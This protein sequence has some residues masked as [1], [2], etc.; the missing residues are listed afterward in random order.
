LRG[1][2][3]TTSSANDG[4][5]GYVSVDGLDLYYKELDLRLEGWS[6]EEFRRS[7]R[8]RCS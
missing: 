8:Q 6:P 4:G 7:R 3:V 1:I 5:H 2:R